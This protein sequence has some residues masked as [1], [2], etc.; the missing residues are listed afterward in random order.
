MSHYLDSA[1]CEDPQRREDL[2]RSDA[3]L[4]AGM[5]PLRRCRATGNHLAAQNDEPEPTEE[6][7]ALFDNE[8]AANKG[9]KL[10]ARGDAHAMDLQVQF[11]GY[12]GE[13]VR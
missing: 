5:F 6:D 2:A 7:W 10:A 12:I 3:A 9:P 8:R 4:I 13:L 1:A 11:Q